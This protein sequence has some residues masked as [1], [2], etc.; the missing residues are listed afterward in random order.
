MSPLYLISVVLAVGLMAYLLFAL[1]F[2][3][4]FS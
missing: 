2:P 3:E 1:L 4:R